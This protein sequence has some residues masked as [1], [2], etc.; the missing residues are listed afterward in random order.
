MSMDVL[1]FFDRRDD[2]ADVL[3]VFDHGI[4]NREVSQR[5]FMTDRHVLIDGCAKLAVI[6]GHDAQQ[7]RS[8]DEVFD[9]YD[10]DIIV[11]IVHQEMGPVVHAFSS[12]TIQAAYNTRLIE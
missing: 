9:D 11:A 7:T 8:G 4:A 10:A 12:L 6:F 1:A 3:A 5:D 2:S